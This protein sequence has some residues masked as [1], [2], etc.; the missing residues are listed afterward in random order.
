MHYF[1]TFVN[2]KIIFPHA[3][4]GLTVNTLPGSTV[5]FVVDLYI[6]YQSLVSFPLAVV[7]TLVIMFAFIAKRMEIRVQPGH[8][9][10][11]L[12]IVFFLYGILLFQ[13]PMFRVLHQ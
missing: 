5:G 9:P 1:L 4:G 13:F 6:F 8:I 11:F 10:D 12:F 2:K 7:D 3:M